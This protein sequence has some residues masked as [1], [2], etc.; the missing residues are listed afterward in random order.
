M[1]K[2]YAFP[3]IQSSGCLALK[4]AVSEKDEYKQ[5]AIEAGALH[6]IVWAMENYPEDILVQIQACTPPTNPASTTVAPD[7]API[8]PEGKA[9][10]S[11]EAGP[12]IPCTF[13]TFILQI[14]MGW[15]GFSFCDLYKRDVLRVM[16]VL[17]QMASKIVVNLCVRKGEVPRAEGCL[18]S[19][20]LL[21][22]PSPCHFL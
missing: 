14:L 1:K 12:I 10:S 7:D 6:A 2:W 18:L 4:R 15:L 20:C 11:P 13:F 5:S 9:A 22:G 8:S 3:N 21:S 16:I 17:E 19:V